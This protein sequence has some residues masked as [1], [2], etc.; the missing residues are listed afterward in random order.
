MEISTGDFT[1][2]WRD[3]YLIKPLADNFGIGS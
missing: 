2:S 3:I 1:D